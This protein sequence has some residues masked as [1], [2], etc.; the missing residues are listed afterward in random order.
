[1]NRLTNLTCKLLSLG[2]AVVLSISVPSTHA[3]EDNVRYTLGVFP[4]LPLRELEQ[5]FSPIAVA[6]S[7]ELGLEVVFR[8]A[9]SYDAFLDH[10]KKNEYHIA[11]A[12]PFD[13]VLVSTTGG[14]E[15]IAA[16][17]GPLDA[18]FAVSAPSSIV[19]MNDLR[20]KRLALPPAD[21]AV[22]QLALAYLTSL[23]IRAEKEIS[24]HYY[25]SHMSCLHQLLIDAA[26]V[27]ATARPP[28]NFFQKK[29][30]VTL[31]VI[32]NSTAISGSLFVAKS[33]LP[34][35]EQSALRRL[36]TELQNSPEGRKMLKAGEFGKFVPI[37][38]AD[39]DN[40]RRLSESL[41]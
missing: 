29:M 16:R 4:Y 37:S 26:D 13:Y 9:T 27:C 7:H 3:A 41:Q 19:T 18:V 40:V 30:N 15:P 28:M 36:L 8:S 6:M 32:G 39:Y 22:S 14:Y 24:V 5:I 1:M 20:G 21:A 35:R 25:K 11:F 31:N 2:L 38:D 17:D 34:K 10:L 12:Q 33:S 23:G